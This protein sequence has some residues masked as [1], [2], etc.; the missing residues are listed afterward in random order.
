MIGYSPKK[1]LDSLP[2]EKLRLKCSLSYSFFALVYEFVVVIHSFE[3]WDI[4]QA[5]FHAANA[6]CN[7]LFVFL[8]NSDA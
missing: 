1:G 4:V 5:L 3:C 7:N 2:N 6:D 8:V